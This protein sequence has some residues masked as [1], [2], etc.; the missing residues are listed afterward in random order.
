MPSIS[1]SVH[2]SSPL[3]AHLPTASLAE[4]IL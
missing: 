3:M 4:I 2:Q 1:E